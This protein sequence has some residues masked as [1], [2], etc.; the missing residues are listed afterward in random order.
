MPSF[1]QRLHNLLYRHF[2]NLR[3]LLD[4][5]VPW[6]PQRV[7]FLIQTWVKC[8]ILIHPLR[9][10]QYFR[11]YFRRR[12]LLP[13]ATRSLP[14][15]EV[16]T[17]VVGTTVIL[18]FFVFRVLRRRPR[19]TFLY[20]RSISSVISYLISGSLAYPKHTFPYCTSG[21]SRMLLK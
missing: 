20:I 18:A 11:R 10:P 13:A 3:Q 7:S 4:A 19:T 2:T 15:F 21:S 9:P 1:D 5:A 17:I 8:F 16:F 12:Q 6:D 14:T